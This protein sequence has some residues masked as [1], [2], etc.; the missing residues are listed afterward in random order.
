MANYIQYANLRDRGERKRFYYLCGPERILVEQIVDDVRGM[1]QPAAINYASLSAAISTEAQVWASLYQYPVDP[2]SRR[3]IIVRDVEKLKEWRRLT[4]WLENRLIPQVTAV[5][6][7]GRNE[8]DTSTA[9][10]KRVVKSGRYVECKG[11]NQDDAHIYLNHICD[12]EPSG[13]AALLLRVGGDLRR[14]RDACT[15]AAAVG[16]KM[17]GRVIDALA[18]KRPGEEFEDALMRGD[19]SAALEAALL[20]DQAELSR[21]VGGL[22]YK[23]ELAGRLA[24]LLRRRV[25]LRSIIQTS[26][27]P[28]FLIKEMLAYVGRYG[29]TEVASRTNALALAD[30]R[31]QAGHRDGLL[32]VL[33]ATW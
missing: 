13:T 28:P 16:M 22:D 33:T 11:L 18:D 4:A 8:V 26:G 23:L 15:A 20:V 12:I 27:I 24:R 14:A 19:K 7:D 32:E 31:L 21:I 10:M 9:H 30:S 3:L 6:V 29:R 25:E 5:F 17:E 1:I 2:L